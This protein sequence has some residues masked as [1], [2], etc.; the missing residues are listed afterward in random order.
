MSHIEF[1]RRKRDH[2]AEY[3]YGYALRL[4]GLFP[5]RGSSGETDKR[6]EKPQP[7]SDEKRE[8]D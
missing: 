8:Q 2:G 5:A 7:E 4:I 1:G 6:D 3:E